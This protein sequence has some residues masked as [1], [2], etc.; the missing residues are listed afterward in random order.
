TIRAVLSGAAAAQRARMSATAVAFETDAAFMIPPGTDRNGVLDRTSCEPHREAPEART[1][2][3]ALSI[4]RD[5][6][7][8]LVW[9]H[10][11]HAARG[12]SLRRK[13]RDGAFRNR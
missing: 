9:R 12:L 3:A 4:A 2:F 11:A 13:G 6:P 5:P 8:P 1:A 7:R 10:G